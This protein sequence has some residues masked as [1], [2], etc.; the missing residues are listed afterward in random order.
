MRKLNCGCG[1]RIAPGWTNIDVYSSGSQV[2]SVNLLK[3]WPF[4]DGSFDVAYS[5]HVLEHFS[6]AEADHLISEVRRVLRSGGILRTVVPDLEATCREYLRI[7]DSRDGDRASK[8]YEWI[9]LELIDQL[10]RSNPSGEMGPYFERLRCSS[11]AE[12]ISYVQGRAGGFKSH[13]EALSVFRKL[14]RMTLRRVRN[15]LFY[16]WLHLV[17]HLFPSQV[18]SQVMVLTGLGERHRWMY[19]RMG[20]DLLLRKHRFVNVVVQQP[21]TSGINGFNEDFLDVEHDGNPYKRTSLY[22]EASKPV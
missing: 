1:S 8:R 11:D 10:A 3:R 13:G 22:V 21:N 4:A 7:L 2:Q 6:P 15:K 5:S 20:L 16:S 17:K 19:D 9:I 12:M 18:R 14:R